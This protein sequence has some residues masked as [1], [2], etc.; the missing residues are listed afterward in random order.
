[1]FL[2][3]ISQMTLANEKLAAARSEARRLRI[4]SE[5]QPL[6]GEH[7]HR[8]VLDAVDAAILRASRGA[9]RRQAAHT[10][11]HPRALTGVPGG[12]QGCGQ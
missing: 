2:D 8:R 5:R 10:E 11:R 3:P 9:A 4:R 1:M 6:A 7:R 12:Q